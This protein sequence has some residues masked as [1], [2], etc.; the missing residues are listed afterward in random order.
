MS[1]N[2]SPATPKNEM[3]VNDRQVQ[4]QAARVNQLLRDLE[5]RLDNNQHTVVTELLAERAVLGAMRAR[6]E[7]EDLKKQ[8]PDADKTVQVEVPINAFNTTKDNPEGEVR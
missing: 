4:E 8:R 7:L 1:E 2:T 6:R 3:T 5:T